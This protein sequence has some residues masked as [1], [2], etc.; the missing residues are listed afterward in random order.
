MNLED[1]LTTCDNCRKEWT[2]R[3]LKAI[4]SPSNL[5]KDGRIDSLEGELPAGEC[6]DCG[7]LCYLRV[8][9][10]RIPKE[11]LPP[12]KVGRDG[13]G[14]PEVLIGY[15]AHDGGRWAM[16]NEE[17]Q[18]EFQKMAQWI[19]DVF[20][21]DYDEKDVVDRFEFLLSH[22][23][24]MGWFIHVPKKVMDELDQVDEERREQINAQAGVQSEEKPG[25]LVQWFVDKFRTKQ[26]NVSE[27]QVSQIACPRC[28]GESITVVEKVD[29]A[30]SR[31]VKIADGRVVGLSAIAV[32][33][34]GKPTSA[35]F[36]CDI[37]SHRWKAPDWVLRLIDEP[38]CNEA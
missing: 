2:T 26:I 15:V 11:L 25:G 7:A 17:S 28:G 18:N 34:P 22:A 33:E 37:C 36:S 31:K 9:S 21:D 35:T 23:V 14:Y 8:R 20:R 10:Y 1:D 5:L 3:E 13:F 29:I 19:I 38:G 24:L 16:K 30:R 4:G 6:P 27:K 12:F 32:E